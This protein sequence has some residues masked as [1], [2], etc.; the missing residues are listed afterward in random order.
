VAAGPPLRVGGETPCGRKAAA[1]LST[2]P[3]STKLRDR[4]GR[5]RVAL[6][7]DSRHP[8]LSEAEQAAVT[9]PVAAIGGPNR[10]GTAAAHP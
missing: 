3:S 7:P 9:S 1:A 4:S 5:D 8:D 6:I 2:I 10:S